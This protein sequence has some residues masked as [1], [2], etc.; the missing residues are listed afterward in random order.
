MYIQLAS[1]FKLREEQIRKLKVSVD[2]SKEL[3]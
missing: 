2:D 1:V 3:V